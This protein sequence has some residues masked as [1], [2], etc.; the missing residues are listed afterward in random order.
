MRALWLAAV[1]ILAVSSFL[2][3]RRRWIW[4]E[5]ASGACG[6]VL[7]A[8]WVWDE[9]VARPPFDRVARVLALGVW[10]IVVALAARFVIFVWAVRAR[11]A[12]GHAPT[13]S[14]GSTA[15]PA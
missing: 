6:C 3:E 9:F 4:T 10:L 7:L 2:K 12:R 14:Q 5:W 1:A 11:H 15:N 8:C 13:D